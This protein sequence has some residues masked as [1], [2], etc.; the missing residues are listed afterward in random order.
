MEETIIKVDVWETPLIS[1]FHKLTTF[2]YQ[3][4]FLKRLVGRLIDHVVANL[5]N[6]SPA[7]IINI[8]KL[9]FESVQNFRC[10]LKRERHHFHFSRIIRFEQFIIEF[11]FVYLCVFMCGESSRYSVEKKPEV[12]DEE[13]VESWKLL[14]AFRGEDDNEKISGKYCCGFK[15]IDDMEES[16]IAFSFSLSLSLS[17]SQNVTFVLFTFWLLY[18]ICDLCVSVLVLVK[19]KCG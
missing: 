10:E 5:P 6:T 11:F 2:I 18:C 16:G 19:V 4:E 9:I 13:T 17:L 8:D 12:I 15:D 7:I 3:H 14:I 1:K